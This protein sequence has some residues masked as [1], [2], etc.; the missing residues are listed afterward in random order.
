MS[1]FSHQSA[2]DA[3]YSMPAEWQDHECCW[4]AWPCSETVWAPH[5]ERAQHGYALVANAIAAFEPVRLLTPPGGL[6]SARACCGSGV[7]IIPWDL[8]DAWLRD[9]GPNFVV[10]KKG[11]LAASVFHFNAWGRKYERYRKDAALG[12][13]MAETLGIPS[14]TAPVYLEGGAICS[15]GEGTLLTTE[16]CVLNANRNPGLNKA[17]ATDILCEALGVEK[18]IWLKGDELDNETDGHVDGLACFVR[19]GVV[20]SEP[21]LDVQPG[22]SRA[23]QLEENARILAD[24]TDARGRALEI[25]TLH[26][27][28]D[29]VSFGDRFCRS[30][31][32]FYIANG[33][34]V[35]P[36]YGI[37]QDE[38]ARQ[39]VQAC[40]P[41]REVVQVDVNYIAYGGGAVHCITQ[42]QPRASLPRPA[43]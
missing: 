33:G 42:Q 13:Q 31:I 2:K 39:I 9:I 14:F 7:E 27:A 15:D 19:P 43:I 12:H 18:V 41:E 22:S 30:Y 5:L 38:D 26:P 32:N 28:G 37:D 17:E 36:G 29:D 1:G 11:E 3:G 25:H 16:Q 35:M 24:A 6:S 34:V 20:L 4:M 40:F 10:N 23:K 8:D 21:D